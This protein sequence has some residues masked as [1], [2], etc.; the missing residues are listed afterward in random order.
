MEKIISPLYMLPPIDWFIKHHNL[1]EITLIN[2][3]LIPNSSLR[4]H[5]KINSA[6]GIQ[7]IIIPLNYN[8]RKLDYQNVKTEDSSIW[9]KKTFKAIKSTYNNS[10]YYELLEFE[11][12]QIFVLNHQNLF[13]LN[14]ELLKWIFKLLELSIKIN[15]IT[16]NSQE[17]ISEKYS[18]NY[19][20][21]FPKNDIYQSELS[22][23]DLI[24]NEGKDSIKYLSR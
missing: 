15:V 1:D 7:K 3:D 16:Q 20:Q 24:F 10:P 13:Q 19:Y 11:L 22:I 23:L 18:V 8:S 12:Q 9:L 4:N 6:N 21:T 17:F 14:N 5:F 2:D